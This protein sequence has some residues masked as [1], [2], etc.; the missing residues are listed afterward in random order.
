[1]GKISLFILL[2]FIAAGA[3]LAP[4]CEHFFHFHKTLKKLVHPGCHPVI[5]PVPFFHGPNR[6]TE[7]KGEKQPSLVLKKVTHI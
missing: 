5:V 3:D 1:M 4:S 6:K 7:V 2:S